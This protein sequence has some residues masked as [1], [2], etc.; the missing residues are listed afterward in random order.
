MNMRQI[1]PLSVA[2]LLVVAAGCGPR[3]GSAD[4]TGAKSGGAGAAPGKPAAESATPV[5]VA[6]AKRETVTRTVPVTG[7]VAA[8]QSIDLS[9]KVSARVVAVAG[10]EGTPVKQGQVVVQQDTSD[11][12]R[13]VQQAEANLQS[14]RAQL[15]QAQT[16]LSLQK[17]DSA[18]AVQNARAGL[19][20]A[21]ANLALAKQPQRTEQ[22]RQA[23]IAVEQ[24]QANYDRAVADRKR[25]EYLVKE[26]AAAQATLDQYVTTEAVQKANLDSAKQSL[27]MSQ[28]GGRAESI[29]ASQEQDRQAEIALRQAQSNVQQVRM[30]EDAVRQAKAGVAQNEAALAYQ[31]Q[32]LADASIVSPIDGVIAARK[33]E[34]GQMA[35]PG[36]AVL[37]VVALNTV[38]FEAQVPETNLATLQP[39][40]PVTVRVD[41]LAG[42]TFSGK[43][44]RIYPTGNAASRIFS[45]RVEV[46][47]GSQ[48][49][50]PGMFA[51]GEAVTQRREGV[52]IPKDAL[53]ATDN[54]FAVFVA[55][56]G[57]R[58]VRREVKVGIQTSETTEI[59]SGVQEGEQVVVTGQD[60][61]RDGRPIR[62]L[63]GSEAAQQT[64][65]L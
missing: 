3:G 44:A 54:G 5:R 50:R 37:T 6:T 61:L 26:G 13:Q 64:A 47:N 24:A 40:Q 57:G 45:V 33:T 60:A 48:T 4:K 63:D 53:V 29:R 20:G 14:A 31:Q 17:T 42:K 21:Q 36:A 11:M 1:A 10:R 43:I 59:L 9:P 58:A 2:L 8:L 27:Q 22:I 56:N 35:A 55:E 28:T 7:S 34:P 38:Y 32:Q 25:Y 19:A 52:V 46:P 16:N 23:E 41:A 15:A 49:L 39:G 18:T 12:A 51:R 30:K 65:S 62:V